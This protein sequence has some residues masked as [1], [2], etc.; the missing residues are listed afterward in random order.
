MLIYKH[1]KGGLAEH[2]GRAP[3]LTIGARNRH[4]RRGRQTA[5]G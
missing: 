3:G 2:R 5:G 4:H 1:A